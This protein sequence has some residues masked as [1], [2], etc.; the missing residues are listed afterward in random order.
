MRVVSVGSGWFVGFL[1]RAM[2]R[3]FPVTVTEA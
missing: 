3:T 1:V 2:R